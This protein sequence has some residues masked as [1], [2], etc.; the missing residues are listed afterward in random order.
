MQEFGC[1][2]NFSRSFFFLAEVGT[3]TKARSQG[4]YDRRVATRSH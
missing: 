4:F 3:E 2:I 1:F